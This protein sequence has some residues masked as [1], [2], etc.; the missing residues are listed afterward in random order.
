MKI[1]CT[2]SDSIVLYIS[3][4]VMIYRKIKVVL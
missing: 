1:V 3:T 2:T 4:S